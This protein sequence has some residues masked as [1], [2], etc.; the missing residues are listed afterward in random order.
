MKA[1]A[2]DGVE[3]PFGDEPALWWIDASGAVHDRPLTD[4]D[5]LPGAFILPGLADAHAHPA[6]GSGPAGLVALDETA[7]RAN[8][9]AWA[10]AGIT[11]VRDVGSPGGLTLELRPGQDLPTVQ[12][13]GLPGT[14]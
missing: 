10:Q 1:W 11:L 5:P 4:A 13:A 6:V 14:G 2:L 9:A 3:L 8:L 7:A 12:A